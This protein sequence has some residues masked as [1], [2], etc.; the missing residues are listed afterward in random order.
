M[1]V[2]VIGSGISGAS[3]AAGLVGHAAVTLFEAD[4]RLGGHSHTV[5]VTLPDHNGQP[6]TH[7]VD[8]GF[9][10]FNPRTYPRLVALFGKLQVPVADADMSFS[11]QAPGWTSGEALEWSGHDL[12]TVFAQRSN[13]LRPR[14]WGMLSDIVRFNRLCTG[15]AMN[16]DAE[17]NLRPLG[18]FL[19]EHRFGPV[20]R[21]GYLLPMLGCIWS[22]PTDQMLQFPVATM[23]RFC[24]NHGLLQ[25][26]NRPQ[27][28]TVA[29][30]S[31][32]Y[33]KRL[34][35]PVT[36][37]RQGCPVRQVVRSGSSVEVVTDQGTERFDHVVI[38]SH[39]DETMAML[40]N[41][42]PTERSVLGAIR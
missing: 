33:V 32:E 34:L 14:F 20:F 26:N 24:H 37:I 31:R 9:L 25:V 30:G 3:A 16:G 22:C 41:P 6:V 17:T 39:S 21:D 13:L 7:G 18:E 28:K 38:A 11:V 12:S 36:D 27:W 2:A 23:V 8:T 5:D 40:A 10:V 19:D 35:A 15:L 42:T 1:K 29:G 4:H